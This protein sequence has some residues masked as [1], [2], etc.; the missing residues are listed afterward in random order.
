MVSNAMYSLIFH[1]G[2]FEVWEHFLALWSASRRRRSAVCHI[3]VRSDDSRSRSHMCRT[4]PAIHSLEPR[5]W[6]VLLRQA[7]GGHPSLET[8]ALLGFQAKDGGSP[9]IR[10]VFS[11]VKSRDFT[12]KVCNPKETRRE[13]ELNCRSQACEVLADAGSRREKSGLRACV[14]IM[15]C[16]SR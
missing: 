1:G 11:P 13:A 10:T 8:L 2:H 5:P 12:I 7:Y 14:Q 15:D 3:E 16:F 6:K 9:R 4:W